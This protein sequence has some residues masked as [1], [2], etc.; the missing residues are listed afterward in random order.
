MKARALF[1]LLALITPLLGCGD[2]EQE[3]AARDWAEIQARDTLTVLTAFNSTGYFVYRGEPMGF[4]YE[5]LEKFAEQHDLVLETRVVNDRAEVLEQLV[6]GRGD[7]AAARLIP[8]RVEAENVAFTQGLYT[9]R[10]TL[11]QQ[12][13]PTSA[14]GLP[15]AVDSVL[16]AAA[17]GAVQIRARR[18]RHPGELAGETVH[19]AS[20]AYLDRLVEISDSIDGDIEVV[21]V[22]GDVS[23]E[24]LIRRVALGEVELAVAPENLAQLHG[25]HFANLEVKPVL[26][27]PREVAWAVRQSSPALLAELDRWLAQDSAQAMAEELYDRYFVDRRGYRERVQ[28]EYLSSATGRL[29][30]YDPLLKRHAP[31]IG[32]DWRLLA[33][34]AYQESKFDAGARSWAGAQGLLQLMPGTARQVGVRNPNDP[35]QNVEGAVRH[36]KGL[37]DT[38]TERIP[39]PSERLRF[40][41]AA[42]NVG[43]G[44]V[45]D[46]QRLAQKHGGDPTRWDDVSY[47]LLNK[48]K[49]E[50]YTDPVV[51]HGFARGLEPVTYVAR[52]LERFDH[53]RQFVTGGE[54]AATSGSATAGR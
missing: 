9:T 6:D 41:L 26:G 43:T 47:W 14:A 39:D 20:S 18:V 13:A 24:A 21:E 51:K 29:S 23:V 30:E 5:L 35:A 25:S 22:E 19:A 4:E 45:Q 11:V 28:S 12:R 53:Y 2:E 54:E 32:W 31:E 46:A 36:L 27:G 15:S 49:R 37:I 17:P 34:Q 3:Q 7:V 52:V 8:D 1:T 50:V 42:Y 10:P 33:S 40:V 38:W 44:H 16:P 48:S